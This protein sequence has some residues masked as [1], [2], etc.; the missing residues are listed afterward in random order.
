MLSFEELGLVIDL[1]TEKITL[2]P[3]EVA[4][5]C[6]IIPLIFKHCVNLKT[7]AIVLRNSSIDICNIESLI[8]SQIPLKLERLEI[9]DS[10]K[11]NNS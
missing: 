8:Q 10:T 5:V 4:G 7:M 2:L 11:R 9:V 3:E 1:V 6:Q